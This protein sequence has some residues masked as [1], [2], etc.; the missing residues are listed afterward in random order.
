MVWHDHTHVTSRET[1]ATTGWFGELVQVKSDR[2][3]SAFGLCFF[4]ILKLSQHR[5]VAQLAARLRQHT[6]ITTLV[7]I[8]SAG[9]LHLGVGGRVLL[10]VICIRDDA[11][12][13]VA[14]RGEAPC[15]Y[16]I[17]GGRSGGPLLTR[18]VWWEWDSPPAS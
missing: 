1:I 14:L 5:Y 2:L 16:Q 3:L 8:L 13:Q 12:G 17:D 18:Y 9:R 4:S 7:G 11:A 10:F 15:H 6:P